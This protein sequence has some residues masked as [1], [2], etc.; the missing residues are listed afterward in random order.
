MDIDETHDRTIIHID[1]DC[2]Y[3]Q[4]EELRNPSLRTRPL[5]IQQK[6]IIVTGN[7]LARK[8]GVGKLMLL[9]EAV[10]RCPE[11]VL[12]RGEDLT[13]YRRMSVR[14]HELLQSYGVPV[15]KLGLDENYMD[16][17]ALVAKRLS[18]AATTNDATA[19]VA[20]A[21]AD[22]HQYPADES[23]DACQCQCGGRLTVAVRLAAEIRHR[24][25]TELG[26]TSCAGIAHNKLLAKWVGSRHKPNAQTVFVP[27]AMARIWR[28]LPTV[29]DITGIGEQTEAALRVV[30]VVTVA[31]LQDIDFVQLER[32]FGNEMATRLR[33][34]SFGRDDG[35]VRSSGRPKSISLEDSCRSISVRADVEEKFRLLLIRLID[36]V[37]EDGR[38]PIV[39]KIIVRKFDA[40]KKSSHRE[41]KQANIVPT[42]LFRVQEG[43]LKL[44]DGGQ[45]KLL[46]I[47]MRLFERVVDLM[48]PFKI[49]LLGLAFA[50]F[51]ERRPV[52]NAAAASAAAIVSPGIGSRSLASF[53][54]KKSDVEVQSITSLSSDGFG[55]AAGG[56]TTASSSSSPN[57]SCENYIPRYVT[58][59]P[60]PMDFD[61]ISD[62][63]HAS[64]D[65]SENEVEPSPKKTRRMGFLMAKRRCMAAATTTTNGSAD[66]FDASS[67]SKL[68]VGD[69]RLN[70]MDRDNSQAAAAAVA[71]TSAP[72]NCSTPQNTFASGSSSSLRP[73]SSMSSA[74]SHLFTSPIHNNSTL[75]SVTSL[76]MSVSPLAINHHNN[77]NNSNISSNNNNNRLVAASDLSAILMECPPTVDQEVFRELPSD[78][79]QELLIQWR[80]GSGGGGGGGNTSQK[81]SPSASSSSTVTHSAASNKSNT[82]HRYFVANKQH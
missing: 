40:A 24:L 13:P 10:R 36:N 74:A 48:R 34:L 21:A 65:V 72:F 78:V 76:S 5:G 56:T 59:S 46:K 16:V 12:V 49:T 80:G 25:H 45:E 67:P 81:T 73:S 9:S 38:I 42:T 18:A 41:T 62:T 70:S 63:S 30:G 43:R 11:L 37:V 2:F 8:H 32:R 53:L 50:K 4:V 29:R 33:Q 7:Y 44:A 61:A 51:Q 54:M 22:H 27:T 28:G 82:L 14:I 52:R 35:A 57:T 1:I 20:A 64:S 79:Q 58:S 71:T 69:L 47:V 60:M 55:A 68:R 15:E 31:Q 3:A 6:N 39:L 75:S 17:T 19:S 23:L 77:N 66:P 26:I